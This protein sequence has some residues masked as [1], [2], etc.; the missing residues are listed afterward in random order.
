VFHPSFGAKR[1]FAY[2]ELVVTVGWEELLL[3]ERAITGELQN[4]ISFKPCR[5][6]IHLYAKV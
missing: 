4:A 1:G 3:V 6:L 5:L 2:Y